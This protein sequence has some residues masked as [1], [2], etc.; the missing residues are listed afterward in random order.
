MAIL[1]N[2]YPPVF[3]KNY[4]PAFVPGSTEECT[5]YF[6]ISSYNNIGELSNYVQV[7]IVNQKTNYSVINGSENLFL[8][9]GSTS[10]PGKY[11][12]KISNNYIEG[13]GFKINNYYK[14]Q[15]RFL[16]G[17]NDDN[18]NSIEQ[19]VRQGK[20]ITS[21]DI[22]NNL[23]L[24][25]EWST[26]C[27]IKPISDFDIVLA[28]WQEDEEDVDTTFYLN[29]ID[30]VGCIKFNQTDETEKLKSFQIILYNE[31]GQELQ[32]SGTIQKNNNEK[33]NEFNYRL[34]YN[35]NSDD[36][37]SLSSY[38]LKVIVTTINLYTKTKS[39][40][41]KLNT[42]TY[43]TF[44]ADIFAEIDEESGSV[45]VNI[46]SNQ[47]GDSGKLSQNIII[48]RTSSRTNFKYWEDVNIRFAELGST[49]NQTWFDRTVEPGIWYKYSAYLRNVTGFKSNIIYTANMVMVNPEDIFLTTGNYQLKLR[50]D[51]QINNFSH[52]VSESL[53]TT[54]GSKYPF[55]RRNGNVNYRS[56]SLS[57]TI[58]A[59]IDLR[60]NS[61]KANY[62]DFYP[63]GKDN[64]KNEIFEAQKEY[65]NKNHIT[66]Y[67]DYI[68]ERFFRERVLQ[69]LYADD[70][71]LFRSA[72]Q[73][74]ILVK[75]MNISLTP[76]NTLGRLIYSFSCTANQVDECTFENFNKYN[77]QKIGEFFY[78]QKVYLAKYGEFLYPS[79]GNYVTGSDNQ[80]YLKNYFP[81]SNMVSTQ[82]S[83]RLNS[84]PYAEEYYN[85][86][87]LN[88][89]KIEF[90][91]PPYPI[92]FNDRGEPTRNIYDVKDSKNISQV[93]NDYLLGHIVTLVG[94]SF[95]GGVKKIIVGPD[96]IYELTDNL[97]LDLLN[98]NDGQT[99]D[100]DEEYS[101]KITGVYFEEQETGRLSYGAI[102]TASTKDNLLPTK[103]S[104]YYRHGQF[105]GIFNTGQSILEKILKKYGNKYIY[106]NGTNQTIVLHSVQ[107]FLKADIEARP[108]T[109]I[110]VIER[111]DPSSSF[112]VINETGYL[113]F[114]DDD[115]DIKDIRFEGVAL[116][117]IEDPQPKM[118]TPAE[119]E[120]FDTG[121]T[122][123][124]NDVIKNPMHNGV[125]TI[126]MNPPG[127]PTVGS[128][129]VGT[130]A[131]GGN[132]DIDVNTVIANIKNYIQTLYEI[133][134]DDNFKIFSE[135][136]EEELTDI[137]NSSSN[138]LNQIET[139]VSN[140]AENKIKDLPVTKVILPFLEDSQ[141]NNL[142]E[143][144][145][146]NQIVQDPGDNKNKY[147]YYN[148]RWS[149]FIVEEDSQTASNYGIVLTSSYGIINYYVKIV[150]KDF[151]N[152]SISNDDEGGN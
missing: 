21:T 103:V 8:P 13:T 146:Y 105:Y 126:L 119:D 59:F 20:E 151:E 91:S 29:D 124:N 46:I 112:H 78:P 43:T 37:A 18:P 3:Q 79:L 27:L 107:S 32:N 97:N 50:F 72:P 23:D 132:S 96:G 58:S 71:K 148:G 116:R 6:T 139:F 85:V 120:W 63:A 60:E 75:L 133:V 102:V 147:I 61:M 118:I 111:G 53:T 125:Y 136:E 122:Y 47:D 131:L 57:G 98:G 140:W 39:F 5:L 62:K 24:F 121:L 48:R 38:N 65:N 144:Y 22:Q 123:F 28:N 31:E 135:Q 44:Q 101:L 117:K 145:I 83:S 15:L 11:F 142:L 149:P 68:Q 88:Y 104:N 49:L 130:A 81:T 95:P 64:S 84:N 19:K 152:T 141:E 108:G 76:N 87:F 41:F 40:N 10:I 106:E 4:A 36:E 69:F 82:I 34:T 67:N 12:I 80:A 25:S 92:Y 14:V 109:V 138:V 30:L 55:I 66:L 52:V 9:M 94:T 33:L 115:T 129:I 90:T 113:S 26:V 89:L 99:I 7:S 17:G 128:A 2:L 73:G 127:A 143:L 1:N 54:L 35:F 134:E 86:E 16:K 51:P 93:P 114:N 100:F 110:R 70:V 42:T 137:I 77:I 150:K 45:K 74:N 56:F